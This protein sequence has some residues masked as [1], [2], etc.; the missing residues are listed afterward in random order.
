MLELNRHTLI[1]AAVSAILCF[2]FNTA[3]TPAIQRPADSAAITRSG[4]SAIAPA[5]NTQAGKLSKGGSPA[6]ENIPVDF[7]RVEVRDSFWSPR[8][9][10]HKRVTLPFCIDQCEK[11]THRVDNFRVS[12]GWKEGGFEGVFY[13]DSDLHK[14]LEGASYTLQNF[15]D[16]KIKASI[17]SIIAAVAAA[18]KPDGYLDTYYILG[19]YSK[20]FTDMD[21][22]EMY[23]AGHLIE[24]GL[25]NLKATGDTI[26]LGAAKR[27]ADCLVRNFQEGK[28]DW[29]PGHPEIE[30][31]LIKLYSL[32]GDGKY[33]S[34]SHR[35][36][37][38]RGRGLGTWPS[39][40]REYY[41]DDAPV[42]D[43]DKIHGHAV[44]AMYLF[45]AMADYSAVTGSDEYLPALDRLWNNVVGSRMYITGGIGSS[46]KNEGFTEDFD[47]PNKESYCETCA[48]VGMAF[49]NQRMN[50]LT[51]DAKYID[52]LE[53]AMY[54]GAL[55]GV[56]LSGDRFFYV[57]PL[58]SDG[59]HHRQ[60][61]YGTACCP[62]QISRFLPSVGGY[63]YAESADGIWVNL[64]V[65]SKVDV[66]AGGKSWTLSMDTRYP[67]DG[68]TAL[69]LDAKS[70]RQAARFALRLRIPGWCRDF[71]IE[72]NGEKAAYRMDRGYA[73]I[74]RKWRGGDK[75][76]LSMDMPIV[77][78]EA[79]P[80]VTADRGRRA[81]SRGP[82]VYCLE[83]ADNADTS[84][85]LL[86]KDVSFSCRYESGLLGGI[87]TITSSNGLRFIPYYA[88]DN[89]APG[90]MEVWVKNMIL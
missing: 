12:A 5:K 29:V 49:W 84:E 23:I 30:L 53:R 1:P 52:V 77:L 48:S 75:V 20:R 38:E 56:S 61:W 69:S 51:G 37:E 70:S 24:A 4:Y 55:A 22:H 64:Y 47:L 7:S 60:P 88:W 67:W 72:V 34:L 17:D 35:L 68:E 78:N 31:A 2:G 73:V 25:A 39:D 36:L 63:I 11:K 65:G 3:H 43:F 46:A 26:L 89:R 59:D 76:R 28:R 42:K 27:F 40:W 87:E 6:V 80:R 85:W 82:L 66:D 10:V 16:P 18:Q 32:T 14:M 79:D 62:S 41:L 9:A 54:N 74:E 86:P 15:P 90:K 8:I 21:K 33:L 58:A 57:N 83:E 19:D 71:T 45:S 50:K 81:V 44:R 13:D